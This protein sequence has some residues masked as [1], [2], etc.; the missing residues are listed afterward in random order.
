MR[1]GMGSERGSMGI[2]NPF[3]VNRRD[4]KCEN[5]IDVARD[6]LD[7]YGV[8]Y[9]VL[10]PP[11]MRVSLTTSIDGG[12]AKAW[13]WNDWQM[14]TWLAADKRYL[15]SICV[16]VNDPAAAA[17]EIHRA[18]EHEQMVQVN[19][20]GESRDL[21][22]HRRYFPIYQ[23]CQDMDLPFCLHPGAEGSYQSSTPVGLPS[24]Y[25]EWHAGIP[26]TFQAHLISLVV[27]GV[28]EKFPK[29][30]L[31]LCEGGIAWLPHTMWRLDKDFKA[32]RST[33]PWLK[34]L[35]SEYIFE[36]VRL[37]TQPLEEPAKAEHLLAIFEIIKAE[38]TL[39]FASDFPHWDFDDPQTAFP[40]K[41]PESLKRRIFYENAA[42]MYGLPTLAKKQA[43]IARE[44]VGV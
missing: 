16:N 37:T 23:A 8:A 1:Q 31:V 40:K 39:C 25:F 4:V 22:G 19:V 27:E 43:E 35:P 11:G 3:G 28:F 41:M 15:G 17:K 38:Q 30:K 24:S 26:I 12:T 2:S 20:S 32:L 13:A 14:K 42:E 44:K 5:P 7:R 21:Y 9:G 6:H 36:H 33:A 29:M 34:R 10:Q 18:G